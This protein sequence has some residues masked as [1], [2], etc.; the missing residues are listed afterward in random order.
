MA[1]FAH[2]AAT[3]R[4]LDVRTAETGSGAMTCRPKKLGQLTTIR[5]K[6]WPASPVD[7]SP[8]PLWP[9]SLRLHLRSRCGAPRLWNLYSNGERTPGEPSPYVHARIAAEAIK[10]E[11]D[12][13]FDLQL[14][15]NYQLGGDTDMFSQLRVG[16]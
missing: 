15:P 13:R 7:A 8:Q 2:D 11:T 16:A 12:G 5:R 10:R 14:F 1:K 3:R 9:A 6:P 4:R